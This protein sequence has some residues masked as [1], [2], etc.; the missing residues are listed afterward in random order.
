MNNILRPGLIDL[1]VN[2]HGGVDFNRLP[3]MVTDVQKVCRSLYQEGVSGFLPTLVTN[4]PN[5][6]ATLLKIILNAAD[7]YNPETEAA[8]LG[9][10]LEGPFISPQPGARGAHDERWVTKPNIDWLRRMQ[11]IADGRIRLLTMAPEGEGSG[12][13]IETACRWGIRVALGHTLATAEQVTEAVQAGARLATHL[14]NGIPPLLARH[15]N[16]LW[17]QL[18]EDKLWASVIGDGFHLPK[19]VFNVIYRIKKEKLILVS[20]STSFTNMQPGRYNVPIGGDVVLTPEGKLHLAEN[21]NLMAGSAMPLRSIVE[22]L[23]KRAW[24]S[25]DEAWAAASLRPWHFLG[26]SGQPPIR[27]ISLN[28]NKSIFS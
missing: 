20:D 8:I 4:D 21:E 15:P 26:F 6:T 3:L 2:G 28:E 25:A 9:V 1:Q 13:F 7:L 12:R 10:H 17:S 11:D 19:E 14:G 27:E 16:P 24:L 22:R 5:L 23:S 18:A